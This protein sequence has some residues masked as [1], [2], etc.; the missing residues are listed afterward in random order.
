M[1]IT[2]HLSIQ[3]SPETIYN[4]V[5]SQEG[6]NAWWAKEGTVGLTEGASS[7][8]KF[9]KG[10][11]I[12][13]MGFRT[14]SLI[15]NQKV[16]WECTENANPAWIGTTIVTEISAD[17]EGRSKV[18]FSHAGFDEKWAGQEPFEMTKGG[19]EHFVNSLVAYCEA[20]VGQPW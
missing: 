20:G 14:Q 1:N 6:I 19:W 5:A 18:V 10:G 11:T 12:V 9:N 17:R 7:L 2:H 16:V 15:P 4:A 13:E 8:L 3:A